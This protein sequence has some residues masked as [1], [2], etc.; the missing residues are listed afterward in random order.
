MESTRMFVLLVA[1][2]SA[3]I[4]GAARA[5]LRWDNFDDNSQGPTWLKLE[6]DSLNCGIDERNGRLELTA[7]GW[8][9][10]RDALYV[11]TWSFV[12]VY[13]FQVKVDFYNEVVSGRWNEVYIGV[14]YR[15]HLEDFDEDYVYLAAGCDD[16]TAGFW[17]EEVRDGNTV[18]AGWKAR[19]SNSGTLYISY[20][21]SH[22]ELYVSDT[23][24]GSANAWKTFSG[25]VQG[26]WLGRLFGA[27][28]GGSSEEVVMGPGEAYLDNFVVDR[29]TLCT[30]IPVGDLDKNC[31]VDFSDLGLFALSWLECNMD[32][33]EACLP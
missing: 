2:A 4:C 23:G 21:A 27:G 18:A 20:S 8:A 25:V 17:Y 3:G 31:G 12:P 29:G 11:S 10:E 9:W 19:L 7:N 28:V 15:R 14:G 6:Q 16:D 5:D 26:E 22:D 13:D 30:E 32:P 1:F 33:V 24:Y